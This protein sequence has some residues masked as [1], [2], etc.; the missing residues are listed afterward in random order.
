MLRFAAAPFEALLLSERSPKI[1]NPILFIGM[2][3]KEP[4]PGSQA[5]GPVLGEITLCRQ[6]RLDDEPKIRGFF[7]MRPTFHL[8]R[9]AHGQVINSTKSAT[10]INLADKRAPK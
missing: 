9:Q 2:Q 10:F 3:R 8:D 6:A 4:S 5:K 1:H 7:R